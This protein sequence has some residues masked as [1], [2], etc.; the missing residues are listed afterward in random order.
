MVNFD[1]Q[2]LDEEI[3]ELLDLYVVGAL[4]EDEL[5]QVKNILSISMLAQSYVDEG[6]NALTLLESDS[7]SDPILFD[8]I[9]S[10]I[11]KTGSFETIK[12]ASGDDEAK[13]LSFEQTRKPKRNV[14]KLFYMGVAASIIAVFVSI[15]IFATMSNNPPALS[16][17]GKKNMQEQL[18][19]FSKSKSTQTLKLEG[20]GTKTIDLMLN[21]DGEVMIDGRALSELPKSETYQLWAIIEDNDS[22]DGVKIISASVMGNKPDI[23]M[24][25][26]DGKVKGFAITK[27]VSGGVSSSS[28]NPIYSHMLA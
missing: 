9:L 2:N 24:T 26:V 20:A 25:H 19:A 4:D 16:A 11:T 5:A 14:S 15:T 28:N 3:L 8:S 18:V 7:N 23:S 21:K 12:S 27:E 10:Q 17:N 6:R 13:V 1:P 22:K